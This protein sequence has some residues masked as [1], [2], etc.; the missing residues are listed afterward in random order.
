MFQT[1]RCATT[2]FHFGRTWNGYVAIRIILFSSTADSSATGGY[3][4][5]PDCSGQSETWAGR[6]VERSK[7][8]RSFVPTVDLIDAVY[9]HM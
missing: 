1:I 3:V 6:N 7:K 9:N 2:L 8:K 4:V 5:A